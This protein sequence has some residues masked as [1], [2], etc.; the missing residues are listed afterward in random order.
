VLSIMVAY[1]SRSIENFLLRIHH[2][3]W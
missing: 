3:T 1:L 2:D